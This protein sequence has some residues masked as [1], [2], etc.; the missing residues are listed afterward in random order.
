MGEIHTKTCLMSSFGSSPFA[1]TCSFV[2]LHTTQITIWEVGR[3]WQLKSIWRN[4]MR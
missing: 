3:T 4:I 2:L 1:L